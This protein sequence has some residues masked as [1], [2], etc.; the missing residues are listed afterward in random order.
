VGQAAEAQT[1]SN[2]DTQNVFASNYDQ[3]CRTD[4]DCVP[5]EEGN[6]CDPGSNNG[7]TNAAINQ[8]ALS[9]YNAALAQ[10]QA[11]VCIGLAGCPEEI[12]PCCRQGIC[13]SHCFAPPSDTLP[14]CADAGGWCSPFV[15]QCGNGEGPPDSCAY[16]DETCCLNPN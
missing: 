1:C 10:T 16:P 12:G 9:R 8:S 5:V 11:G 6:F 7:C 15:V 13:T 2:P 3:S 4:S 14:G